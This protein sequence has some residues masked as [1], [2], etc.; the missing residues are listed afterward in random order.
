VGGRSQKKSR[1]QQTY[2]N[3]PEQFHRLTSFAL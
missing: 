1:Q 3:E 2:S